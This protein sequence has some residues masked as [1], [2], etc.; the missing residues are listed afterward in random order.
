MRIFQNLYL[1]TCQIQLNQ[2]SLMYFQKWHYSESTVNFRTSKIEENKCTIQKKNWSSKSYNNLLFNI[3]DG[4]SE[5]LSLANLRDD[6]LASGSPVEEKK[7]R[8]TSSPG[9]FKFFWYWNY[10]CINCS[11]W[12]SWTKRRRSPSHKT[13]NFYDGTTFRYQICK[14][15][16]E[17]LM[18]N[19][20]GLQSCWAKKQA[21]Q[22]WR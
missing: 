16:D 14:L 21:A 8:P 3:Q 19:G 11:Y 1:T 20:N 4:K 12:K 9:N 22:K 2:N 17:W 15:F 18:R 6:S 7:Q 5:K 10:S 13:A